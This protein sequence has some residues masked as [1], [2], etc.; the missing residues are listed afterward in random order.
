VE[1]TDLIKATKGIGYGDICLGIFFL[2]FGTYFLGLISVGPADDIAHLIRSSAYLCIIL[3][4]YIMGTGIYLVW[5]ASQM[6]FLEKEN[7][8]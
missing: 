2:L 8:R 7:F 3:G 6:R 1:K 4:V 5:L